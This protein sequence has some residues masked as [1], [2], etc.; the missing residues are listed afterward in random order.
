MKG[1]SDEWWFMPPAT[2]H[3]ITDSAAQELPIHWVYDIEQLQSRFRVLEPFYLHH[4]ERSQDRASMDNQRLRVPIGRTV[5][6]VLEGMTPEELTLL[7][8]EAESVV[9]VLN[10][11]KIVHTAVDGESVRLCANVLQ[12]DRSCMHQCE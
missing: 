4:W 8:L 6:E 7:M 1:L 9:E 11:S 2:V 10:I 5:L 12:G 3:V